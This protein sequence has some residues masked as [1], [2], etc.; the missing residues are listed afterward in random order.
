MRNRH[1]AITTL[2]VTTSA[3]CAAGPATDPPTERHPTA[4]ET[5]AW[6][7]FSA[8]SPWNTTIADGAAIDADSAALIADLASSAPGGRRLHINM[9]Q[10]TIPLY[11]AD[12][13]TP[14]V[15]VRASIGGL[16]F[17]TSNG[18]DGSAS[19]RVP[20]DAMPD[21][22]SDGHLLVIDRTTNTEW[23]FFQ[24]RRD[25]GGWGCTL[26]AAM[27][28][29]GTGVRPF[30][31]R[32]PTWYTSHG[33]RA[34]GFPLVAGLL[35][36]GSVRAGRVDHALVIAY[37]H[38]RAGTYTLPA[39]TA[40]SRIGDQAIAGR[41][42]PCGGRIQLDPTLDLD[43]LGLSPGGKVV[44]RALQEYG[45]Y[46]GDYSDGITLYADGSPAA[47]AAWRG[48]LSDHDLASLDLHRL[49]VLQLG[50]LTNDGNGD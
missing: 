2:I 24:A 41:G 31:P 46:V 38:I 17:V 47:R 26:C 12:A 45:A 4:A 22:M 8:D 44:A 40:Q 10:W 32:N 35:R 25:G 34:C 30:K 21:S 49:R 20:V 14:R 7:P 9:D 18:F 6:R 43:T 39:T 48:L 11:W 23:G 15:T 13:T 16:G 1:S 37:R 19:V 42:I 33:P 5:S 29:G 36:P 3:A 28:L 27:D 50:P